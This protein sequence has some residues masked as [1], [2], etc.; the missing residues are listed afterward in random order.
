MKNEDVL[1]YL[2]EISDNTLKTLYDLTDY[3]TGEG[4][5]SD[6]EDYGL[7]M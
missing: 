1:G 7:T 5:H 6:P 4:A 2:G 3:E